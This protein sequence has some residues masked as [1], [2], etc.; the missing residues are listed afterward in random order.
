MWINYL[1][2]ALKTS[3]DWFWRGWRGGKICWTWRQCRL[4]ASL[5]LFLQEFWLVW[6]FSLLCPCF[7]T[8]SLDRSTL[9]WFQP[10][11]VRKEMF[12]RYS[13]ANR[14]GEAVAKHLRLWLKNLFGKIL[15]GT[16]SAV[17]PGSDLRTPCSRERGK[18]H[19][20][21]IKLTTRTFKFTSNRLFWTF[22]RELIQFTVSKET[23]GAFFLGTQGLNLASFGFRSPFQHQWEFVSPDAYLFEGYTSCPIQHNPFSSSECVSLN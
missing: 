15:I 6:T 20:R 14:R 9:A 23:V 4:F 16:I 2:P 18:D 7:R 10:R 3:R 5:R 13:T 21:N 22:L 17:R 12:A 1:G 8:N 19:S 11:S